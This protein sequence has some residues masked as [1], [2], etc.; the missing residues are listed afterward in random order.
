MITGDLL[1]DV[2]AGGQRASGAAAGDS[3]DSTSD[4]DAAP[5]PRPVTAPTTGWPRRLAAPA[6]W[7]GRL[8]VA[9]RWFAIVLALATAIRVVVM[10]GYPPI[11]WFNDSY[12]YVTDAATKTPDV[13]RS[14]GYP[15]L[16]Y[17]LLPFHSLTLLAALQA[18][19]GL[20]MGVGIYAVLRRRGL[21]WW[22]ATL[23]ALPVLFDVFELQLEH[24]V[25]SD[26]L[27]IFLITAA[28]V[29]L[30]WSD[31]P[32][33]ITCAV[34][35]LLIGYA[36]LVRTVGEPLLIVVAILLLVRRVNW[37]RA[38]TLLVV[39]LL[40]IGGYMV[41]FH[42]FYG[43]Y[44]LDTSSG[45][46]LYSRVSAFAE[47]SQMKS[48]PAD[49]KV[50]CD[51]RPLSKRSNSQQYLWDTTTP[52]YKYTHGN[53]FTEQ[54]SSMAGKFAK[55]AI[56]SQPVDYAKV[57]WDDTMHTFT[58]DRSQS[59][60][61]GSGPSYQF[62]IAVDAVPWWATYYPQDKAALLEYGGPSMGQPKVVDPWADFVQGYQ[63]LVYLRGTMLAVILAIGF[64][65]IVVRWRRWG[66]LALLPWA[67]AALLIVLP[68]MTAGFSYRYV[69]AAAP[70][71]CLAAGLACSREPRRSRKA[72]AAAVASEQPA[73]TGEHAPART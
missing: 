53:N 1:A 13:V 56:M 72:A 11:L 37:K 71:A 47:C 19:M 24:M 61:T 17:V 49:L 20:A 68:A 55:I 46:F 54:A 4:S 14:N 15:L 45:T 5:R 62:R 70:V 29:A 42:G 30:C 31:Q 25:M 66:G 69:I 16:L 52:L 38:A 73:G 48:L 28:I 51:P 57:V 27:F 41:W 60:V 22:G 36:A 18:L 65:G 10:L 63:K 23:P 39:G 9:H 26:V 32:S 6:R 21:P 59:D 33:L 50:L 35:G 64:G 3:S 40:P 12:N 44:A 34:V 2:T 7:A 43:Q 58:W 8:I 67:M